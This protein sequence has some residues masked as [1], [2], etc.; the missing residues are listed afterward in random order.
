MKIHVLEALQNSGNDYVSGEHLSEVLG[1]S[2]TMVW[3]II[4]QLR[5]EGYQIESSSRKGYRL[6]GNNDLFSQAGLSLL[7]K[8]EMG[9][10]RVEY[11]E[12]IDSTNL[13]AKR[14]ALQTDESRVLIVA[15][16]QES[17]RGRLGR[18]WHSEKGTGLWFSLLLKPDI[19]PETSFRVTLIAA[20]SVSQAIK[21]ITGLSSGIKWP[22]DI[23]VNR[24][25]VCGILSEMSAEWQKINYLVIGIG[26]N[27]NQE[28][29][30]DEIAQIATS[31][32]KESGEQVNR[33]E[34]LRECV[35]CFCYYEQALYNETR[36][37][38]LLTAYR[39]QSVTIGRQV[40]VIGKEERL[41]EA[42]EINDQGALLVAFDTGEKEYVNYGEVSVRGIDFYVD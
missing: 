26:I 6:L 22:N 42:L 19:V 28:N 20:V 32:K 21:N 17:G 34:L 38:E 27:A 31:L 11:H 41:G 37:E 13:Q 9:V 39:E 12:S 15:D 29:F 23:V 10:K 14:L 5:A 18:N 35:A 2:R 40:R 8:S 3:K 4:S 36:L 30:P 1:V 25:K 16:Q 33:M 24:K 7:F